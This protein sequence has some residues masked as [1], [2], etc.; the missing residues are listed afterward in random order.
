MQIGEVIDNKTLCRLYGVASMGGIRVNRDRNLIVLVSNPA[1]TTAFRNRQDG[2][3]VQ[4]V[5]RGSKGPQELSRQNATLAKSRANG[6]RIFYFESAGKGRFAYRGEFQLTGEPS[7]EAQLD[8]IGRDRFVWVFPLSRVAAEGWPSPTNIA[9]APYLPADTYA[10]IKGPLSDAQR[11]VVDRCLN[12]LR[13]HAIP[14]V[15][16][17]DVDV[18]RYEA[19]LVRWHDQVMAVARSTVRSRIRELRSEAKAKKRP[20][21][22]AVDEVAVLDHYGEREL[23]QVLG[24]V[25]LS[26]TFA[27]LME[28]ARCSCPQPDPPVIAGD[29]PPLDLPRPTK[30]GRVSGEKLFDIT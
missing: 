28:D 1:A 5:G 25:G 22:F 7:R 20:F 26:D 15:S 14:V 4:F 3:T 2:D 16:Q 24:I 13:G 9:S 11:K 23:E 12:E 27:S 30:T 18:A 21:G 17:I 29:E 8:A 10:L 19:A 6:A